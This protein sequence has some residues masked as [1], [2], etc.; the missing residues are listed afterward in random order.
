MQLVNLVNPVDI[1]GE[2]KNS[3][4]DMLVYKIRLS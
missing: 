3:R 2:E 4:F 1:V